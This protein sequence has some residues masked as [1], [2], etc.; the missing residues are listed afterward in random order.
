MPEK[1]HPIAEKFIAPARIKPSWWRILVS[2]AILVG[3][4]AGYL[5]AAFGLAAVFMAEGQLAL[6]YLQ[7]ET[8]IFDS[9]VS[10]LALLISFGGGLAGIWLAVVIM[11]HRGIASLL[12][13]S[14]L[15]M[16][17]FAVAIF[18]VAILFGIFQIIVPSDEPLIPNMELGVWMSWLPWALPLLLLQVGTEE[19]VFRGYLQQQFAALSSSRI[20][21]AVIPSAIF[22]FLHYQ[23]EQYGGNA[24]LVVLATGVFGLLL[25]E[26][27]MRTGNLGAAI[28]IHFAN[29]FLAMM[30]VSLQGDLTGMALFVTPFSIDDTDLVT[31]YLLMD[32]ALALVVLAIFYF[33]HFKWRPLG[34]QSASE[35]NK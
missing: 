22:G 13:P 25:A 3:V 28:G 5:T 29:N 9:P 8:G 26:I 31:T 34:L 32:I 1:F 15:W 12:G 17:N 21:W 16:R 6:L 11:H 19:I 35:Q 10:V 20:V 14:L 30:L 7:L 4:Y 18:A 27:T 2:L 23:P 33:Y 24:L